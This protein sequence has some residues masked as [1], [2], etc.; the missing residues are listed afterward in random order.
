MQIRSLNNEFREYE[1]TVYSILHIF[2]DLETQT[3]LHNFDC[4]N[5]ENFELLQVNKGLMKTAIS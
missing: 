5:I 3:I 2:I 1:A 4:I